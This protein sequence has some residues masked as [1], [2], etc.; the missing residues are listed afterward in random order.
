MAGT[1]GAY[2]T[3]MSIVSMI[4]VGETKWLNGGGDGRAC[5]DTCC[6]ASVERTTATTPTPADRRQRRY[7][8]LS[9]LR[10]QNTRNHRFQVPRQQLL[11][12]GSPPNTDKNPHPTAQRKAIPFLVKRREREG[13]TPSAL[14]LHHAPPRELRSSSSIIIGSSNSSSIS[15]HPSRGRRS[16]LPRRSLTLDRRRPGGDVA[17]G[18]PAPACQ[19]FARRAQ[20]PGLLGRHSPQPRPRRDAVQPL[21]RAA[22]RR[23][24]LLRGARA[25]QRW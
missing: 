17:L 22:A 1:R 11:L 2:S 7:F 3:I 25:R 21:P 13:A 19:N 5:A 24:R 10:P 8:P 4:I 18:T 6:T 16:S 15:R 12:P 14:L 20:R 9:P 23:V